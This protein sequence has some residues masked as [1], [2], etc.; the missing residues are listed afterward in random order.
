M[1]R[2]VAVLLVAGS[3]Q[4]HPARAAPTP[5]QAA[6]SAILTERNVAVRMRDGVV[7]RANVFRPA[8]EGPWPVLVLR[9]PY[10]KDAQ[11]GEPYV[12]AGYIVVTQD[13]R[14]RYASAGKWESFYRFDT[15]DAADGYDTVE[16]A[17][18]LPGSNGKVGTFGVSYNAFLQWRLAPLRPPSLVAMCARSIPARL[19]QLEGPGTIRPGR[20]LNW[21]YTGMSPDMRLRSGAEGVKTKAEAVKLWKGGEDQRLLQFLPWLNL[22]INVFEDEKD[23]VEAWLSEP[24]REPWQFVENCAEISV[25]NLDICGWF[26][27]CNDGIEMHQAMRR[28]G[29]TETAR[30]GQ[31]LIIGPWSHSGAGASK[32][33][34][35]DFGKA[36]ALDTKQAEI[37]YFDYWLKGKPN[38]VNKDAPVRIFVMGVNRWRDEQEW[39]PARAVSKAFHLHSGGQANTPSGDGTLTPESAATGRDIYRY[40]PHDPVP[41]LWSPSMFTLPA[42]QAP[43]A[44]RDDVLVYQTTPLTTAMEVTGYPEVILHAASSAPD[45][46]FFARLIDVAPDGTNRDI[47]SGMVRA[48]YRDGLDKPKLLTPGEVIEYRIK[49]RP[50]SNEFQPGHRIRLDIT[51]SDF[52]N[53][54]R[55]HNTAADQNADAKL[56]IATQT[57]HHGGVTASRLILP[58]ISKPGQ[59]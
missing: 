18:K 55:N 45:T 25:P 56:E 23:A 35:V 54:D 29:K 31:R 21:F 38:G 2:I 22:P 40:D 32:V 7:L 39:P 58:V 43:L 15:H 59:P 9:T 5:A 46:D 4:L 8:G 13:A 14:G 28:V 30:N 17:A 48:R 12:N 27:H 37:R 36:A 47:A 41:T 3:L 44:K 16:W 33:G 50:T 11:K 51:S 20:R 57:I 26:D 42:D 24:H 6:G 34:G 1:K 10:G 53:Y 52:P 19:T 49:L